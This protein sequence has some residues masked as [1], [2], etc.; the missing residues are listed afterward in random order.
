MRAFNL[1]ENFPRLRKSPGFVKTA[2]EPCECP[3]PAR[4]C[5][6]ENADE[7][8]LGPHHKKNIVTGIC[9]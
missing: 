9:N 7:A 6:D 4:A 5:D 1:L 3:V 2:G 8:F